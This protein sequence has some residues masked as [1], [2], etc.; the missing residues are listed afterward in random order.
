MWNSLSL[1]VSET[2]KIDSERIASLLNG[3]IAQMLRR[4]LAHAGVLSQEASFSKRLI[5]LVEVFP[6][7]GKQAAMDSPL[8]LLSV[9]EN[10]TFGKTHL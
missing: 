9:P 2:P 6:G 8:T 10:P 4:D 1:Q 3:A 7:R 5:G